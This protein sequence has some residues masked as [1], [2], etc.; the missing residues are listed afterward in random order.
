MEVRRTRIKLKINP[1]HEYLGRVTDDFDK[2]LLKTY[3]KCWFRDEMFDPSFQFEDKTYRIPKMTRL[4]D[5]FD[6]VET[7]PNYDSGKVFGL[8]PLANDRFV[9]K[10][11]SFKYKRFSNL[12]IKKIQLEKFLIQS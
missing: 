9:G 4:D 2:R 5:V 12:D 8:S 1:K 10:K 11:I 6:Y 3:V 7:M